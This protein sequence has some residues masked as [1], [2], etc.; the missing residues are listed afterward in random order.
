MN[1]D[2]TAREPAPGHDVQPTRERHR[3]AGSL[4]LEPATVY[5]V[6][7]RRMVEDLASEVTAMRSRIDTMFWVVI[8]SVVSDV[9]LRLAA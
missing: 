4:D 1:W 5:E 2:W 8:V 9:L 7:T 3:A 6:I